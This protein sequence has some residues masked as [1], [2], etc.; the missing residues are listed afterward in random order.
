MISD[1]LH[2]WTPNDM[3][4]YIWQFLVKGK[5]EEFCS[6]NVLEHLSCNYFLY[7]NSYSV[8]STYDINRIDR[9]LNSLYQDGKLTRIYKSK[10]IYNAPKKGS[11]IEKIS[12]LNNRKNI[13]SVSVPYFTIIPI[14]KIREKKINSILE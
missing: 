6:E 7:P 4:Y 5:E 8:G 10:E 2:K 3:Y 1:A 9:L 11:L 13:H 12:A 14:Y